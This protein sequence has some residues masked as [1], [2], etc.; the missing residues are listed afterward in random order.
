MAK[1]KALPPEVSPV[2]RFAALFAGYELYYGTYDTSNQ[3]I[4]EAGKVQGSAKTVKGKVELAQ[5]AAHLDGTGKGLGII[6][7][8]EDD[9]VV[10]GAIDYDNKQMDHAAALARIQQ[11]HLPLVLC[12]SKSGGGHFY[13]F[14]AE[15]IPGALMRERL[16]EWKALLGMAATT[17]VFPKQSTR[18]SPDDVG[19]WINVPYQHAAKTV[20]YAILPDAPH[21]TLEQF[22]DYAEAHLV[23]AEKMQ[24]SWVTP[25]AGSLFQKGPPCLV[26]LEAQ[27]GFMEG[28]RNNGMAAVAVY[29][30]K[31]YPD[32][33]QQHMDEYNKVMTGGALGSDEIIHI[34]KTHQRKT[35]NYQCKLPPLNAFCQRGKCLKQEF[36]VG[37]ADEDEAAKVAIGGL[38]RYDTPYGDDPMW[39][40]ELNGKRVMV[41]NA[42]LL[43]KAAFNRACLAQVNEVPVI[44]PP[45][46]WEKRVQKLV[47]TADVVQLPADASPTG[48]LLQQVESFCLDQVSATTKEG[49]LNGVPYYEDGRVYFRSSD[50][51]KY[52]KARKVEYESE[53]KVFMVLKKEGAE[54]DFWH[55]KSKSVNV[56]SLPAPVAPDT[57]DTPVVSFKTK[58]EF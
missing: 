27:G 37:Q 16:D 14:T 7:L 33:W 49:I 55:L 50:L 48:Q 13:C 24:Q 1:K 2:E 17:E 3:K 31:R 53:Q 22:L 4:D 40:M 47:Q 52:L 11:L 46:K 38:V 44:G 15:P 29:L 5:F 39:A 58:E 20:R 45:S 54:K 57:K 30:R 34:K 21:A 9:T 42:D 28:S 6:M 35:Y 26:M 56:W 18:F 10:F 41:S 8:R 19:S 12:R 32:N 36:G 25:S 23:P 51:F 43:N